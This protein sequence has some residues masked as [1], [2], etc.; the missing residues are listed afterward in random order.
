VGL[1]RQHVAEARD[2]DELGGLGK[3]LLEPAGV[4][5]RREPVVLAHHHQRRHGDACD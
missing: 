4:W 2:L 3:R 5:R 1:E